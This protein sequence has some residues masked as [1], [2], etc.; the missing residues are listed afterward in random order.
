M[1]MRGTRIAGPGCRWRGVTLD[2][3]ERKLAEAA[4]LRSEKLAAMGRLA[5]TVA[6]E[7]NNPLEAVTNLLYLIRNE[8]LPETARGYLATAERELARLGTITRLTLG[9]VRSNASS[10]CVEVAATVDDVLSIFQHRLDTRR[11]SVERLYEPD[12]FIEMPPHELRQIATNLVANATDAVPLGSARIAITICRNAQTA[13]LIVQDNG[14]GIDAIHL[15][16]IFEPFFSTKKE[17]GTGIGLWVTR[18]LVEKNGGSISVESSP[19]AEGYRTAFRIEFP[20]VASR[21]S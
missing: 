1:E 9:F 11:V 20:L 7:I 3:T 14:P 4:V 13:V 19:G 10:S 17:V 12:V 15:S 2:I 16:R 8:E 6:H 5:S 21:P 18:E